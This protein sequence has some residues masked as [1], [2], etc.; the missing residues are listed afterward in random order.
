M[1]RNETDSRADCCGDDELNPGL[2]TVAEAQARIMDGVGM[3]DGTEKMPVRDAL[4]LSLI[5][6]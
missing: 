5:H 4:D 2:L 3:L 6:I 1:Q